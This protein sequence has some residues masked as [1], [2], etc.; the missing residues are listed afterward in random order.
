MKSRVI[1]SR[2][3]GEGSPRHRRRGSLAALGMTLALGCVSAAPQQQSTAPLNEPEIQI[4]QLS[5]VAEIARDI[6]GPISVQYQVHVGNRTGVPITI[7]RID[8]SSIGEGAYTLRQNS[9]PFNQ[10]LDTGHAAALTLWAP[11][12][13][14]NPTI[15]GANG[16]VTLRVAVQYDTPNGSHQAIRVE[17][18]HAFGGVD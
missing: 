2:G 8:V 1:L 12:F 10:P 16:P 3:D 7:K 11:A 18:V 4:H 15:V 6:T 17:Q 9:T 5:N 13:I 14:S